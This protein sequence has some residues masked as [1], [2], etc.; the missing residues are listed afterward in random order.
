M[1]ACAY[2]LCLERLPSAYIIEGAGPPNAFTFGDDDAPVIVIDGR[3][4]HGMGSDE[5]R[6]LFGHEMGHIKSRHLLYHSLAEM[7]AQGM[8]ISGSF[9]GLGLISTPMRLALLAWQRE[10]EFSADRA[11]LIVSGNPYHVASMFA[12]LGGLSNRSIAGETSFLGDISTIFSTHPMLRERVNGVFQFSN[13]EEYA[14]ILRRLKDRKMLSNAFTH[15]CRFC[16]SP[17]NIQTIFC[18]KCKKSL[19]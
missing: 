17:K 10:S 9:V 1:R 4:V 19:A 7:L 13:S 14:K 18:P 15:I 12:M 11:A 16:G 3:L 2:A 6:C 8:G 5:L